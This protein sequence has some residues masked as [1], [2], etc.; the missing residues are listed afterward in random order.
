MQDELLFQSIEETGRRLD[1]REKSSF[2][3]LMQSAKK[4]VVYLG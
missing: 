2:G 3:R 1:L 4:Q